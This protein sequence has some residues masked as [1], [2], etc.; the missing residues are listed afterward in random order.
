MQ[1]PDFRVRVFEDGHLAEVF[2]ISRE[3]RSVSDDEKAAYEAFVQEYFPENQRGPYLSTLDH[4][5]VPAKLPGYSRVLAAAGGRIWARIYAVDPTSSE[6][7]EVFDPNG[8]WLG[9]VTAP[10]GFELMSVGADRMVGVWRGELGVEYV[11][12]FRLH[13]S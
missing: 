3:P 6:A 13:R 10:D 7:W 9:G 1:G 5:Q 4:P 11:Q 8:L 12:V 2:G